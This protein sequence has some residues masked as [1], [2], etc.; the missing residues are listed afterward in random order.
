VLKFKKKFWRQRVNDLYSPII[1]CVIKSRGMRWAG[2]VARIAEGRDV[3][4][5][6]M[7]KPEG[8]RPFGRHRRRWRILLK[9]ILRKL[10]VGEWTG[11]IWLRIGICGGPL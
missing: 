9:W 4:R 5:V 2:H 10:D 8:K 11:S 6:L 7:G 3:Y 1:M